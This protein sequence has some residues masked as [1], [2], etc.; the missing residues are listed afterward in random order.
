MRIFRFVIA[1]ALLSLIGC[2]KEV[3]QLTE[4]VSLSQS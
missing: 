1:I 2:R 4:I 3:E